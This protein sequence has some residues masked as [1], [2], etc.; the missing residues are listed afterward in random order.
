M[1]VKPLCLIVQALESEY[2]T[3]ESPLFRVEHLLTGFGK[4]SAAVG[5]T[6]AIVELKPDF[7]VNIGTAGSVNHAVGSIIVCNRFVD[8]DIAKLKTLDGC[9]ESTSDCSALKPYFDFASFGV[10]NTGDQ[11]VTSPEGDEDVY[12]MEAFALSRVCNLFGIPFVAIKYVTDRIGENSVKIW[13]ER[14][15]DS[16]RDLTLYMNNIVNCQVDVPV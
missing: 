5:I 15:A 12:D 14:L 4:V 1:K 16:R 13:E 10:C 3:F 2:V 11:F 7:V 9:W 8:R 6:K